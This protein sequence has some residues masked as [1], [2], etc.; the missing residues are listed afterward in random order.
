MAPCCFGHWFRV[1]G[2]ALGGPTNASEAQ[3]VL[4]HHA[5]TSSQVHGHGRPPISSAPSL[6]VQLLLPTASTEKAKPL[7][8]KGAASPSTARPL[9]ATAPTATRGRGVS[10]GTAPA[11]G[12]GRKKKRRVLEE[13]DE[14]IDSDEEKMDHEL[15]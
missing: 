10:R 12:R 8:P 7:T 4:S 15:D 11:V 5:S 3:S 13:D 14:D 6:A 9:A 2:T 1:A